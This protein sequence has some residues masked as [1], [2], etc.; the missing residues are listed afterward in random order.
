MQVSVETTSAL[1]RR[2]R[3]QLPEER[4]TGEVETRLRD[5]ARTASIKGFR[6][7]KV[8]FKMVRQRYASQV[9]ED[10]LNDLIQSTYF[11]ALAQENLRPAGYPSFQPDDTDA[12]EGFSY[13]A[14]FEVFPD[15]Q[16]AALD[17]VSIEQP[18]A[19]VTDD[20]VNAMLENLRKQHASWQAVEREAANDDRVTV[21]FH[22]TIEGE[23]FQ[24]NKG[25][26]VPVTLGG[27][28]MIDGFE[29]GLI[30]A[31][32][33]E[34]RTLNLQFPENYGHA[35]VAGKPVQFKVRVKQVEAP[36]LPELDDA[37]AE[38]FGIEGGVETL[39][40]DVRS[41]MERELEQRLAELKKRRVMD[42]LLEINNVD[43]PQSL[44][45]QEAQAL[46]KQMIDNMQL[47][48][49]Q[50]GSLAPSMFEEQARRR[51]T[52]GLLL[53]ELIKVNALKADA[54]AVR[55]KVEFMAASYEEPEEMVKWFYSDS[56]RL[57][58]VES[59][60][61]EEAVVDWVLGQVQTTE[62][63]LTFSELTQTVQA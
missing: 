15:I 40:N 23:D 3:V 6:P 7:G 38:K 16:P 21:E 24:G 50:A 62:Q 60:V 52:L 54:D 9:R 10:V 36:E 45:M 12:G 47:S 41:N 53:A 26:N 58:Q 27:K 59:L 48:A 22:G 43:V 56:D 5:L 17:G 49:D 20:D 19:T 29:D 8:P 1:E 46:A 11:E 4:I 61:L 13:A 14:V 34:E 51:V 44:V 42:K 33:G 18:S 2:M 31:R 32:A 55:R 37:F 57:S 35:D 39:R 30:G 25:E 63:N 28:R